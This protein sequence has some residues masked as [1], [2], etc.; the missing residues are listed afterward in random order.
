MPA[1]GEC[2]G[3]SIYDQAEHLRPRLVASCTGCETVQDHVEYKIIVE[4]NSQIVGNTQKRFSAFL[5]LHDQIAQELGLRP[6]PLGKAL[7][8][9]TSLRT[10][11]IAGLG[12]YV[13]DTLS[14]AS[15]S[16]KPI[17]PLLQVF[18][19]LNQRSAVVSGADGVEEEDE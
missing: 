13:D 19:G 3:T 17:P 11:R 7:F 16:G 8:D 6:F 10:S 1:V 4:A 14:R 9:T 18:L 5:E 2:A 12:K 15:A